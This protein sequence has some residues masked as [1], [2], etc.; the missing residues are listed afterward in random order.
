MN[1]GSTFHRWTL[2][3][4]AVWSLAAVHAA[5]AGIGDSP[6]P[7]FS[8]GKPSMAVLRTTGVVSRDGTATVFF[9]TS[10]DNL[11]LDIGVEVFDAAGAIQNDVNGGV[12]AVLNVAAGATVT[13]STNSTAA[14]LETSVIPVSP[15]FS[16]G[17]ARV[18]ATSSNVKCNV[19]LVANATTPPTSL[20]TLGEAIQPSAGASPSAIALPQFSDGSPATHVVVFPGLIKRDHMET[21][22]FCTS[23]A[24]VGIDV[25]VQV[26]ATSGSV[27][28][29]IPADNGAVLDV[30]PGETVTF[31]TTGTA[32]L[33]ETSVIVIPGVA[34]GVARVVSTS[35]QV[36]C[37]AV[38]LDASLAPPTDVSNLI[39]RGAGTTGGGATLPA[40]LPQFSDGKP[41]VH[42]TT[43]PG[44]MKRDRLQT[45]FVCSSLASTPVD[46]GVQIFDLNGIL[47]NDVSAGV[48]AVLNVAPGATATIGTSTT[49]GY[50]E[51]IVIPLQNGLQGVGRVVASSALV[52]CTTLVVDD[53]VSPPTSVA[54]LEAGV[55]PSAGAAPS[56]IALPQFSNGHQATAAV[57]FPGAVKRSDVETDI[58]C[59]SLAR[60]PI[61]V[62]VQI[63]N[64]NGTVANN[65]SAGNGALLG[66]AP[67][68]TVTFGTTGSAALL[69]TQVITIPGVAQGMARVVSNSRALLCSALVLDAALAP[70]SAMTALTGF[71]AKCGDGIVQPGEQCDGSSA[72]AC[73]GNCGA[74][75]LCP[76]V[77][78]DGFLHSSEACDDGNLAAGDC[79]SPTCQ[80]ECDDGNLCTQD[81]CNPANGACT[82]DAAPSA[83]C[84]TPGK[85][86]F[87]VKQGDTDSK[88]QLKWK[89]GNGPLV[90]Y[91]DFGNPDSTTPYTLCIYD[92]TGGIGTLAT[93]LG[94]PPSPLW[95]G[96]PG[97]GW[98]YVDA[99]ATSD[100]FSAVR[101][102]A[103]ST[104]RSR[105]QVKASGSNI[106]MPSPVSG[107]R[108]FDQQP[109]VT[110]QLMNDET[111]ACW[112][113]TFTTALANDAVRFKAKAP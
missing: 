23:I 113:S 91:D 31:G 99:A 85:T 89:W 69:E 24:T 80:L 6:L 12:G 108:F 112:K 55:Q 107:T 37:S 100:G 1:S 43:V 52:S 3:F 90:L 8:D 5:A 77:C 14:F 92:S 74:E 17:S 50:S 61:D 26:L 66:V 68:G 18:V 59:T 41:S 70:P 35:A 7:L 103:G 56:T 110:V 36:L 42:I 58:F 86:K 40:A 72:A 98:T 82:I 46:I 27:A 4:C 34:Q 30:A 106:P 67:R 39:G 79:C 65:V 73:P 47:L 21:A 84:F 64:P 13:F 76:P 63:L 49:A 78:G 45:L 20:A 94:L 111:S 62:G 16:Q 33:L 11:A 93:D 88:N 38:S 53:L 102:Q 71:G 44:A 9:C 105:V 87:Q 54:S 32:A 96:T 19:M 15:S 101:L 95:I 29:S 60:G 81:S 75:C 97:R 109:S 104:G 2:L 28:N 51:T 57:Y 25:G 48:G 22:V 83:S 10:L